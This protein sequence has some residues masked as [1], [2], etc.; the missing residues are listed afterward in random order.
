MNHVYPYPLSWKLF[1]FFFCHFHSCGIL[2]WNSLI[3]GHLLS[4]PPTPYIQS[5]KWNVAIELMLLLWSICC[6]WNTIN[7]DNNN[8]LMETKSL[9]HW[10][11]KKREKYYHIAHISYSVS[12]FSMK[13]IY[14]YMYNIYCK[15]T[16]DEQTH[17]K[18][19]ERYTK[20][21]WISIA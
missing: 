2:E 11:G 10:S 6:V 1:G 12:I 9:L 16:Q 8:K 18:K 17:T 14:I 5:S 4:S 3:F 20:I 7:D 15:V 13:Y 19:Y 21:G